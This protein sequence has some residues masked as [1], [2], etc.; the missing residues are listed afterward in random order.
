MEIQYLN[1]ALFSLLSSI[2]IQ[3]YINKRRWGYQFL[4]YAQIL[5]ISHSF[6]QHSHEWWCQDA[7]HETAGTSN[8]TDGEELGL[9]TVL[10][11]SD[12]RNTKNYGFTMYTTKQKLINLQVLD[13]FGVLE[14]FERNSC[15]IITA[16]ISVKRNIYLAELIPHSTKTELQQLN[17]PLWVVLTATV[18]QQGLQRFY[19]RG[20]WENYQQ[21]TW[22]I[23]DILTKVGT[24]CS[25]EKL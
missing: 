24:M 14:Q 20:S 4:L 6:W 16:Q 1:F 22:K 10:Y 7:V 12:L 5:C 25:V 17:W 19:Y 13:T 21:L 9:Y 18:R 2:I 23:K 15:K 3:I 11:Y 8:N